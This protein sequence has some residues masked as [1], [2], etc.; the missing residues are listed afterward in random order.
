[1]KSATNYIISPFMNSAFIPGPVLVPGQPLSPPSGK[2]YYMDM[3]PGTAGSFALE[4]HNIKLKVGNTLKR[5]TIP[6]GTEGIKL[7]P[8]IWIVINKMSYGEYR[9]VFKTKDALINNRTSYEQRKGPAAEITVH[10]NHYPSVKSLVRRFDRDD[11]TV[12]TCDLT[13][14]YDY[15]IISKQKMYEI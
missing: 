3:E 4:F 11:R 10:H 15:V 8:K 5:S 9:E 6:L 13:P 1:M 14:N 12:Y 7:K 2:I